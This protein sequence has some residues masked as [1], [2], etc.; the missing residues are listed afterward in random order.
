MSDRYH[1][2]CA[3][4]QILRVAVTT[5]RAA[6]N[7][8][9]YTWHFD[10]MDLMSA[11]GLASGQQYAMHHILGAGCNSLQVQKKQKKVNMYG[12]CQQSGSFICSFMMLKEHSKHDGQICKMLI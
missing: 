6:S 11:P 10:A 8:P 2:D 1:D 12:M 7:Q 3:K 9:Y 5:Y 4:P